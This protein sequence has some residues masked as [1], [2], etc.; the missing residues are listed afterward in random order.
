M[1]VEVENVLVESES[2]LDSVTNWVT[3]FIYLCG[4]CTFSWRTSIGAW[5]HISVEFVEWFIVV[6]HAGVTGV[7]RMDKL[8]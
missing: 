2:K 1:A 7:V 8:K 5:I 3:R 6:P 4:Q